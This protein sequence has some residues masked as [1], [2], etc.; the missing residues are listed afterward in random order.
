VRDNVERRLREVAAEAGRSGRL[1]AATAVRARGEQRRRRRAVAVTALSVVLLGGAAAA[2]AVV[3]DRGW[4]GAGPQPAVQPSTATPTPTPTP[5]G[6]RWAGSTQF[7]EIQ[8]G[9]VRDGRVYLRIRPAKKEILGESFATVTIPGP[10]TEVTL[11]DN[12]RIV[13]LDGGTS[14]PEAFVADL[15]RR[16]PNRPNH[17]QPDQRKEGFDVTFDREGRVTRVN[18]LYVM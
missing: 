4:L 1:R 5:D 16:D 17:V 7:M 8:R 14:T 10:Y 13:K 3:V 12:A 9:Q 15:A 18:W 2:G 6:R 11:A